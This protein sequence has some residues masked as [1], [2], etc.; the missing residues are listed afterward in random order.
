MIDNN[1]LDKF[2]KNGIIKVSNFLS[3]HEFDKIKN[4]V[5]FYSAEKGDN[6]SYFITGYKS[7]VANVLKFNFN[8]IKN[9]FFLK[10]FSEKKKI[11]FMTDQIL[12]KKSYLN[13][14][15]GYCSP[16]SDRDVIPWHVDQAYK[17]VEKLKSGYVNPDNYFLKIFIYLTKVDPKNGC[18]NY[19][20]GSHLLAYAIRKGIY[21]GKISYQP[22][23]HLKDFRKILL[24]KDNFN[25]FKNYFTNTEPLDQFINDTKFIDENKDTDK[26]DYSANPGDMIIFDEGGVHRGSKTLKNERVVLRYLYSI[27]RNCQ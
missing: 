10:N 21:E 19:I 11:N 14:I 5:K 22:Y 15:D 23:W 16:V 2:K 25:Y 24:N 27:K 12:E 3:E 9:S 4:I 20:P 7:F 18:M 1:F 26:Y 8:K 17:G 6:K 13:Y